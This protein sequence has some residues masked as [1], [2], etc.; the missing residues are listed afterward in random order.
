MLF[1]SY[2]LSTFSCRYREKK[3]LIHL[4]LCDSLDTPTVIKHIRE[5]ITNSNTYMNAQSSPTPN[6][7]LLEN[8]AQYVSYL[9][10]V[11]GVINTNESIGFPVE[12]GQTGNTVRCNDC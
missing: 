1:L 3:G 10:K 7:K 5:L 6:A 8:I 12:T 4:A 2:F 9:L 11:F